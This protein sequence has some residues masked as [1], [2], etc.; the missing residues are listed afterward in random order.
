M[1]FIFVRHCPFLLYPTFLV[2]DSVAVRVCSC[3][4]P[5]LKLFTMRAFYIFGEMHNDLFL[6]F[7][8]TSALVARCVLDRVSVPPRIA[9]DIFDGT[10]W[11]GTEFTCTCFLCKF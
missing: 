2:Q 9:F 10:Q 1:F 5:C 3:I 11:R 8:T 6:N 7:R 4:C